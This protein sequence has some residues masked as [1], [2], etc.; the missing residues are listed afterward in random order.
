M[1][2]SKWHPFLILL[3][4]LERF[5]YRRADKIITLLPKA[6]EYIE[7]LNVPKDKIIWIPNGV[8]LGRFNVSEGNSNLKYNKS[9]FLITY[10]GAIG[11][12]NNLDILIEVAEKLNKNYPEIKFLLVG[13][14]PE[15]ERLVRISKEK[16]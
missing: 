14:G 1:G 3:G 13:D 5:L 9:S 2:M 11:K 6:Y 10:T 15:K 4:I 16:T 8:N 12:A 7:K